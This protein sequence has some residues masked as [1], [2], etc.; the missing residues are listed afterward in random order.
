V[1][2]TN[3]KKQIRID[4]DDLNKYVKLGWT[5]GICQKTTIGY[6]K[7]TNGTNNIAIN[8]NNLEQI[9]HYLENGWKKG[10]TRIIKKHIWV[11][12]GKQ[13]K[14]ILESE[15][16]KY[17]SEGWTKGRLKKDMPIHKPN[18]KIVSKNGIAIQI[19]ESDLQKYLDDGWAKGN[20][21]INPVTNN[22]KIVI[23]KDGKNKFIYPDDLQKY[24]DDG[25]AKG[26]IKKQK[27]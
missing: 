27:V 22:G 2:I 7:L 10:V 19:N 16:D 11:N 17:L 18:I 21:N 13:S 9:K 1:W 20:C 8:P 5:K 12:N 26:K 14:M 4:K 15:L 25:W 24:L 6:V 23:N 3:G